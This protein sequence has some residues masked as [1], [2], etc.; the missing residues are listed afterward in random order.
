[1]G[2]HI[3]YRNPS[4]CNDY[5]THVGIG[6]PRQK[7]PSQES[8]ICCS[9]LV[10]ETVVGGGKFPARV[11]ESKNDDPNNFPGMLLAN[12]RLPKGSKTIKLSWFAITFWTKTGKYLCPRFLFRCFAD[13]A[14]ISSGSSQSIIGWTAS[15]I[16]RKLPGKSCSMTFEKKRG[17][18]S[19]QKLWEKVS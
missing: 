12:S 10:I 5:H 13:K 16:H 3:T 8:E 14:Q 7:V 1:M 9:K 11:L 6:S 15:E 4:C 19:P 17:E 18:E 2:D